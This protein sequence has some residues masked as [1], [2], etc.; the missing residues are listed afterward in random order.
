V[1][2]KEGKIGDKA[3]ERTDRRKYLGKVG[4][5]AAAWYLEKKGWKVLERNYRCRFGEIDLIVLDGNVLVFVE[6]R[7]RSSASFGT[8]QES[9][10]YKKQNKLRS[11]ARYY[12]MDR[13]VKY[14]ISGYRFDVLAVKIDRE[15]G[16]TERIEHIK[17]AF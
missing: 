2:R 9:V 11:L 7:T 6:V 4:E 13:Q 14:K 12:M 15:S 16:K 17:N 1:K 5:A 10:G 3:R 8:P